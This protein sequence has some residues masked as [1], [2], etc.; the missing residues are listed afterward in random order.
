MRFLKLN[1]VCRGDQGLV[2]VDEG[3]PTMV[4][5]HLPAQKSYEELRVQGLPLTPNPQPSTLNPQPSILNPRPST[6]NPQRSI[7]N[8]QPSTLDPEAD[9]PSP[10]RREIVRR[11][12]RRAQGSNPQTSTL[13]LDPSTLK[14]QP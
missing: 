2:E 6:L 13:N 5:P 8:P 11:V 9:Q 14:P 3:G 1:G 4:N 12:A 10:S 7:F